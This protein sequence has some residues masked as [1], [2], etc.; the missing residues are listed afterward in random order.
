MSNCVHAV[1]MLTPYDGPACFAL[2]FAVLLA[3]LRMRALLY[4]VYVVPALLRCTGQR[5]HGPPAAAAHQRSQHLPVL[6]FSGPCACLSL[7]HLA[8]VEE[9]YERVDPV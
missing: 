5:P 1:R 3:A 6:S 9:R 2:S 4:R 8:V 7:L